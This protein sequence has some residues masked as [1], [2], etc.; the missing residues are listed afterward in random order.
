MSSTAIVLGG[1][2]G[3]GLATVEALIDRGHR[4]GIVARGQD[5]LDT[6]AARYGDRIATASADVSD[7]AA[8][9]TA[10]TGLIERLDVPRIWVN[11]AMLTA[12]STFEQ[13]PVD[14]FDRIMAVTFGGQVNGTRIALRVM[15]RGAIVNVGSGLSYRSVPM[16]SAY[17]AAK[18]AINGFTSAVR[19]ELIAARRPISLSLVQLPA[20]NTPQFDWAQNRMDMKPQPAPP[21]FAPSVAARAI[22]RAADEG[23]REL[24]V[25][26]SVLELV[27]GNMA[28]PDYLDHRLAR[29]GRDMQ[30]SDTPESGADDSNMWQPAAHAATANGRFTDQASDHAVIVD[31]DTARKVGIGALALGGA[32]VGLALGRLLPR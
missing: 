1:S 23:P 5:R 2:A 18:S 11:S 32:L 27:G 8:L 14:E 22:L 25:G 16:Q 20:I 7:A 15:D 13:M 24:L 31:G 12:F 10:V 28:L 3:V 17:C 26:R 19:S 30:K 29:D 21:I 9:D 6:L 4:V